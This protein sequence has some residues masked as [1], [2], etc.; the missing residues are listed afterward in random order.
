MVQKLNK[1]RY[2]KGKKSPTYQIENVQPNIDT[3]TDSVAIQKLVNNKRPSSKPSIF[4][5]KDVVTRG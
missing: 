5:I 3:F 4:L 1:L 2:L